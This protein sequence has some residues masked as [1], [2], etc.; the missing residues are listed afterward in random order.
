MTI[1]ALGLVRWNERKEYNSKIREM[2]SKIIFHENKSKQLQFDNDSLSSKVQTKDRQLDSLAN[3]IH[4]KEGV[5]SGIKKRLK[6]VTN[7][8]FSTVSDSEVVS[9]LS[10]IRTED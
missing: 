10:N 6:N 7:T 1:I 8:D 9:I 2:N 3:L 5:I 4:E